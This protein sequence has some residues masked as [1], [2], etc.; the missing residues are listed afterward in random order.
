MRQ[1]SSSMTL[2]GRSLT[3]DVD[4]AGRSRALNEGWDGAVPGLA[5]RGH[6]QASRGRPRRRDAD[7]ATSC[8][9]AQTPQAFVA[10]VLRRASAGDVSRA[11]DCASLV[12]ARGGRVK[13]VEGDP[14]LI[15][16]TDAEDLERVAVAA[17]IVD[18]H[19]HLRDRARGA[20]A[21]HV[22]SSSL[23]SRRPRRRCRRDRLHRARLLLH[24]RRRSLWSVPYQ[25][26]RCVYDIEPYVDAVV[27]ARE[28]GLPVK[29]GLEVDYVRGREDETRELLAPYP[30]DYLLGS[31]HF[32]DGLRDRR[33]SRGC[34]IRLGVEEA[35]RMY[36]D[37][38]AAA[39]QR[40]D[41]STR[42][43]IRIS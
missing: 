20:C 7:R 23:S 2:R 18:Y 38:L 31:V 41:S 43:L 17:V 22:R 11:T 12:E 21:R 3:E 10:D 13:V 30:W 35:W 37:T 39:A 15:K 5:A 16:I 9:A 32:I 25:I 36:F 24:A 27:E 29:L 14:R 34:S 1:S 4:R 26:E 28:R 6:G 8:A 19:M 33:R 42:C 40:A